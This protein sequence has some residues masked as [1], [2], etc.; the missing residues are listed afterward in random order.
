MIDSLVRE[1]TPAKKVKVERIG[2]DLQDLHLLEPDRLE[3]GDRFLPT[4]HHSQAGPAVG[5]P[6]RHAVHQT[7]GVQKG[8]HRVLP[9]VEKMTARRNV[10]H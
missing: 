10:D 8:P 6:D 1:G 4:P 7:D 3:H 5:Q 2:R 9:V